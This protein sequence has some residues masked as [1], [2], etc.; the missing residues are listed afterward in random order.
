MVKKNKA[1]EAFESYRYI[2]AKG[3]NAT[4][5]NI[6]TMRSKAL[7]P[8]GATTIKEVEACIVKWKSDIAYVKNVVEKYDG[9][10][11]DDRKSILVNML[12]EAL[13]LVMAPHFKTK[14]TYA[15]FEKG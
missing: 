6:I 2:I 9:P 15:A 10:S 13:Q 3:T 14:G 5:M 11:E 8:Q 7:R 1:K 12:P 4:A